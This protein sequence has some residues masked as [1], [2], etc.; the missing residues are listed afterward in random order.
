MLT[1]DP[2]ADPLQAVIHPEDF[3]HLTGKTAFF[4]LGIPNG[5][6]WRIKGKTSCGQAYDRLHYPLDE[7]GRTR[8]DATVHNRF[9]AGSDRAVPPSERGVFWRKRF[10]VP[11]GLWPECSPGRRKMGL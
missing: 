4:G 11:K 3:S 7:S 1:A 10:C 2:Q 9:S 5:E 6:V 8:A